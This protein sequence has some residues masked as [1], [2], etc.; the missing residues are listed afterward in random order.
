[1]D[2]LGFATTDVCLPGP[3]FAG[4]LAG[5]AALYRAKERIV[6]QTIDDLRNQVSRLFD[7]KYPGG[8]GP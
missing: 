3:L 7:D 8:G 5:L 1:M 6:R 4:L 2:L